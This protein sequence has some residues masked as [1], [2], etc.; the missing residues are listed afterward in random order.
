MPYVRSLALAGPLA[1][2]LVEAL[3]VANCEPSPTLSRALD[4]I[5]LNQP[6]TK[7]EAAQLGRDIETDRRPLGPEED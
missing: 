3:K 7:D 1:D 4:R 2:L 6:I 5:R